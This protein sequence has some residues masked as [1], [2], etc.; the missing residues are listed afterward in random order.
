MMSDN[1][2]SYLNDIRAAGQAHIL[3]QTI[4]SD[5]Y[6]EN[7]RKLQ[8]FCKIFQKCLESLKSCSN[9]PECFRK[10]QRFLE[11][12]KIFEIFPK[13]FRHFE[14]FRVRG[15]QPSQCL[16]SRLREEVTS[17]NIQCILYTFI[18]PFLNHF[19]RCYHILDVSGRFYK[20]LKQLRT[21][22]IFLEDA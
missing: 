21:F 4:H 5:R 2:E 22:L 7:L 3:I 13:M 8:H 11:F 16:C 1:R 14:I 17:S 10:F 6:S 12:F 15:V 9:V 20:N 18:E 19:T